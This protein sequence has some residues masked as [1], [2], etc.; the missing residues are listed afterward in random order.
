MAMGHLIPV[1]SKSA[2]LVPASQV[3]AVA[4][5][6]VSDGLVALVLHP[7]SPTAAATS[8]APKARPTVTVQAQPILGVSTWSSPPAV[9]A[10]NAVPASNSTSSEPS[11]E[12]SHTPTA[13]PSSAEP[14]ERPER[15]ERP[16][17][18]SSATSEPG[19]NAGEGAAPGDD[20][21]DQTSASST[22]ET[23]QTRTRGGHGDN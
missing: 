16:E 4:T 10:A 12:P 23:S 19:D 22:T 6:K 20:Q 14:R 9:H 5:P 11:S 21:G 15:P 2:N 18:T 7:H 13:T 17:P 8:T 3:V 1:S